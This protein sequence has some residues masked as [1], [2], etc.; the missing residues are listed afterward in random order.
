MAGAL[1][2]DGS[3]L[4]IC[5]VEYLTPGSKISV[6]SADDEECTLEDVDGK[7]EQSIRE[8]NREMWESEQFSDYVVKVGSKEIKARR[9]ILEQHSPVFRSMFNNESMIEAKEGIIDIQ[10]AKYESV[11]AMVE[12]MYTGSTD[13]MDSNSVDK[14]LAIADKYEVLPLKEQS[15]RIISN[16]ITQKNITSIAVFADTYTATLLKQ[17]VIECLTVHHKNI[18]RTPE[19]RAMKKDRYELANEL[20][21]AVLSATL[22][23]DEENM[24]NSSKGPA[25]KRVRRCVNTK[26]Y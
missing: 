4:L 20:L 17:A 24:S 23:M 1:R 5:E 18:I 21:E 26:Q 8:S 11:R 3:L 14:V 13:T 16:T 22:D 19:W 12:F 15:D 2:A 9:C 25:R 7:V 10:D 6:E